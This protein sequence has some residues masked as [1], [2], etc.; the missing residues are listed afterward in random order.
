V[1]LYYRPGEVRKVIAGRPG[2]TYREGE[3]LRFWEETVGTGAAFKATEY[4]ETS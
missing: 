4:G 3:R 1:S 2:E